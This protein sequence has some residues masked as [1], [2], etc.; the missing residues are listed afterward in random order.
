MSFTVSQTFGIN[1]EELFDWIV[2]EVELNNFD[3]LHRAISHV[4]CTIL[5]GKDISSPS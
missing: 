2:S 1:S 5:R 3:I 4:N